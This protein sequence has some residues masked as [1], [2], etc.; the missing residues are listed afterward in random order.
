MYSQNILVKV[1]ELYYYK[2]YSQKEISKEI[3]VSEA[4]V[5][6]ML[7]EALESGIIKVEIKNINNRINRMEEKIEKIYGLEKAVIIETP[8][9]RNDN[10]LKKMIGKE[11]SLLFLN[12][13]NSGEKV[14]IGAGSTIHEMINS[15]DGKKNIGIQLLPI[16]GGWGL[17]ELD[18]ETNKLVGEMANLLKCNYLL[19][20]SP[21]VVSSKR[22]K[23]L[24]IKEP[25]IK[26]VI[27]FWNYLDTVIFSIGPEIDFSLI[28]TLIE[29]PDKIVKMKKKGAV[30]D[31]AGRIIDEKG[32]E[33][34]IPFNDRLISISLE[35]L[36]KVPKRIGIGGG[37]A[38]KHRSIKA[39]LEGGL[40]NYLVTDYDTCKYIINK[41]E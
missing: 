6:R 38:T 13:C 32:Q 23:N 8:S 1:A 24:I 17:R 21:A 30:G 31:I 26:Q 29:D 16:M 2:K 35:K 41:E 11:A 37:G 3:G 40:L 22:I 9:D 20:L 15:F 25:Q 36:K 27:N 7:N 5:S 12:V 33:V 19:V 10:N 4:T 39:A 14:G 34:E 18:K 28:P